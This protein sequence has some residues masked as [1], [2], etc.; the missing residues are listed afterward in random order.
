MTPLLEQSIAECPKVNK[1]V[2]NLIFQS[3]DFEQYRRICP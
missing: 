3:E 1:L 2:V